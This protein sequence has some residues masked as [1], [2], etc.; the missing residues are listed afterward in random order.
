MTVFTPWAVSLEADETAL[1]AT[2]ELDPSRVVHQTVHQN[3]ASVVALMGRLGSRKAIPEHR[4]KYFTDPHFSGVSRGK[5]HQQVFESNGCRG[6][7]ILRHV[8]FLQFLRYFLFGAA[9]PP[10]AMVDFS[11]RVRECGNVTSGD[12]DPLCKAAKRIT[13]AYHLTPS[14]AAEEF[15]RLALDCHLSPDYADFVRKAVKSIR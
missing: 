10:A 13:R 9:L 5:S 14:G 1:L 8:H 15:Y 7:D 3:G 11:E 12:V 4:L 2:I 6:E